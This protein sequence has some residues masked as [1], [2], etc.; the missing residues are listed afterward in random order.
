[1]KKILTIALLTTT[2]AACSDVPSGHVGI[3]VHKYGESK[4]VDLEEVKPGRYWLSW[5]Q[6]LFTFPTF[7]QTDTY[8]KTS[9]DDQSI[10]FQTRE[11]LT[12]NADI[13]VTFN[14]EPQK[15]P[16][17]FQKY[18]KGISEISD[19]Y[20]RNI[21]RDAIVTE[22]STKSIESVYGQGKSEIMNAVEAR[23]RDQVGHIGI[24]VENI[25]WVGE[26]RLPQTVVNSLNDKIAAT[27]KAQQRENEVAQA[28]AEAQKQI[29]TARGEAD[30]IL[31][32]AQSQAK[33]NELVSKSLTKDLV[34]YKALEK[35]D[36][37]LP[38]FTGS[39]PV[40]FIQVDQ[41]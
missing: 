8:S 39:G 35:W 27:Q 20:L 1:M 3:K 11:G 29:E 13:G 34:N 24:N 5:N 23:V 14:I 36:G 2:L 7:T 17:I 28:K 15:V 37:V 25:Y 12:V 10:T 19:L 6:E 31:L 38:K 22:T 40:P 18:R 9:K 41:K 16:V 4:G 32:R 33:A 30:S 21:I 26:M